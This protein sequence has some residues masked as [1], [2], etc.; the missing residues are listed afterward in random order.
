VS[1]RSCA[2]RFLDLLLILGRSLANGANFAPKL[3]L[4]VGCHHHP[5][6]AAARLHM[7]DAA[8]A[9]RSRLAAAVQA[10]PLPQL[11]DPTA[12][13]LAAGGGAEAW[14]GSRG[15]G[16]GG[17]PERRKRAQKGRSSR[18]SGVGGDDDAGGVAYGADAAL[19]VAAVA[20]AALAGGADASAG[21]AGAA[22]LQFASFGGWGGPAD[23]AS[24]GALVFNR[25]DKC[26]AVFATPAAL[27][28]GSGGADGS[29]F[30]VQ[31]ST[32]LKLG[33]VVDFAV[34]LRND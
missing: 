4:F 27:G 15:S 5:Q 23:V 22:G 6:S 11:P 28:S 17:A 26:R 30:P 31:S 32:V 33:G 14:S 7:R 1:R 18:G 19:T 34:K 12:A 24:E 20:A 29:S 3:G 25:R 13:T 8:L 9:L 10:P 21:A 16:G 2:N